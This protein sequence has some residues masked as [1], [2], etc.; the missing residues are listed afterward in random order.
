MNEQQPQVRIRVNVGTTVKGVHTYDCTVELI[1]PVEMIG[2]DPAKVPSAQHLGELSE[3][4]LAESARIGGI[5]DE[6]YG[7]EYEVK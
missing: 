3:R 4:A 1:V 7:H 5:L 2:V 6:K